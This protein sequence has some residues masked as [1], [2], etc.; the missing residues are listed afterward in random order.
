MKKFA[1]FITLT[2]FLAV[3]LFSQ[4]KFALVIGNGNYTNVT[5]LSNPVNDANDMEAA[6]K[7]LGW[8]VDKVL[9]GTQD[10]M[11][12]AIMQ[13]KRRLGASHDSYGFLFYAGH[14]IQSNGENYLIP[15][16]ANIPSENFLRNRTI[17]VQEMLDE[18]NEAGNEFNH[19]PLCVLCPFV[20]FV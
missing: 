16:D 19:L 3:G 18:L 17:A 6:L 9:N 14:G 12:N 2:F 8:T 1:V 13:L 20:F 15:V 7:G 11:V 5:K 10:Q 4:Q